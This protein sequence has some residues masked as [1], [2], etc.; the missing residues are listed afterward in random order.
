MFQLA[1]LR[2]GKRNVS[3]SCY[4]AWRDNELHKVSQKIAVAVPMGHIEL[5]LKF[6]PIA[7]LAI[8]INKIIN[9]A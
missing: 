8:A 3:F 9:H 6:M 1:E 4:T 7:A 2:R 5:A